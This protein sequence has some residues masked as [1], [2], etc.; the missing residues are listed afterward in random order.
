MKEKFH[1]KTRTI[2]VTTHCHVAKIGAPVN[3]K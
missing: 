3:F 2:Y 1:R